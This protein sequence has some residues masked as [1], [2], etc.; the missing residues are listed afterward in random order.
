[1]H[2]GPCRSCGA[3]RVDVTTPAGEAMLN[4]RARRIGGE[5]PRA[6]LDTH[7]GYVLFNLACVF[8]GAVILSRHTPTVDPHVLSPRTVRLVAIVI[9]FG[10]GRLAAALLAGVGWLTLGA[11]R[12][13]QR[14]E[15][16]RHGALAP[17]TRAPDADDVEVTDG[18]WIEGVVRA[19]GP[20]VTLGA[21]VEGVAV[22]AAGESRACEIADA[23]VS[24]MSLERADGSRVRVE[25]DAGVVCVPWGG[26]RF[27]LGD[28]APAAWGVA[29]ARSPRSRVRLPAARAVETW[30][31]GDGAS[32]RVRGGT[33]EEHDGVVSIRGTSD[34]PVV[35][36]FSRPEPWPASA[37]R[38]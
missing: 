25:V 13:V 9:G 31:F 11:V 10:V 23:S 2:D 18:E 20:P 28:S 7:L 12:S 29:R 30:A 14:I 32:V 33:R 34:A 8:A 22:G 27:V 15:R 35:L 36:Q 5:E 1:V 21:G 3:A 37:G 24:P 19:V 26:E 38:E 6:R 16:R 4:D 17:A